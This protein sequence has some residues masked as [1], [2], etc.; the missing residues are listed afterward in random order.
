MKPWQ[1]ALISVTL[2]ANTAQA[3]PPKR[4]ERIV[5]VNHC[6]DQFLLYL[7]LGDRVRSLSFHA[8]DKGL[9]PH[10]HRLPDVPLNRGRAAEILPLK[11]DL[12]VGGTWGASFALGRLEALGVPVQRLEPVTNLAETAA[13]LQQLG[14][15][16]GHDVAPHLHALAKARANIQARA[17]GKPKPTALAIEA[18]GLTTG[19]GSLRDDLMQLAG[20]TNLATAHGIK[21]YG[22]LSLEQILALKPDILIH[23]PYA[24][25]RPALAEDIFR[26][27][28]FDPWRQSGRLITIP[29]ATFNCGTPRALM[30]AKLMRDAA[31]RWAASQ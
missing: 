10:A 29:T 18:R 6:A 7:A 24:P 5:S 30:A 27:P 2:L 25:N 17:H 4:P 15:A 31:D 22:R 26:H 19:P 9:S 8:A 14:T 3:A 20:L 12:V 13:I 1:A 21:A 23:V 11:P 28:A 16:T